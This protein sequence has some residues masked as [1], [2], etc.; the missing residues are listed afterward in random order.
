MT[1]RPEDLM[2]GYLLG[3]LFA[4]ERVRIEAIMGTGA[5]TSPEE[6][7]A[8]ATVHSV[9]LYTIPT[10]PSPRVRENLMASLTGRMRLLPFRDRIAKFLEVDIDSAYT[11]L[12]TV[13]HRVGWTQADDGVRTRLIMSGRR[14]H[15][16][17]LL[18]APAGSVLPRPAA[19]TSAELFVLQGE[20]RDDEGEIAGAGALLRRPLGSRYRHEVQDGGEAIV[21]ALTREHADES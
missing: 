17:S 8:L 21:L 9:A 13:D 14:D 12:T 5:V 18:R 20:L 19:G 4:D 2:A 1:T 6:G 7:S 3:E 16:A 15:D 10:K 11:I